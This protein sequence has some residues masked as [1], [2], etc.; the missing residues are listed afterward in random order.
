MANHT[1]SGN[2]PE[3]VNFSWLELASGFWEEFSRIIGDPGSSP[4]EIED[5][6]SEENSLKDKYR[7]YK[8]WKTG[9][10]NLTTFI[11]MITRQD[12]REAV[13]EAMVTFFEFLTQITG[14]SSEN[15]LEF[16]SQLLDS[17]SRIGEHT[18]AYNFDDI[19][20]HIFESFRKLYNTEFKKYL[21]IPKLGLPRFHIERISVLIDKYN[22]YYSYLNEL[23]YLFFVPLEKTN[24]IMQSKIDE[25]MT[26]KDFAAD[27]GRLYNEWIKMLEG[28]YMKLLQS[29][30]YTGT[31]KNT[32]NALADYRKSKNEVVCLF[33]KNLPIP[34]NREMDDIYKELYMM[35]KQIKELAHQL[36][37]INSRSADPAC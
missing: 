10:K 1:N 19:D 2:E 18:R 33:L 36:D 23:I 9:L 27:S 4:V 29:G 35:K 17:I 7:T 16:Q 3:R 5:D 8:T 24:R 34:T 37:Q 30:E 21:Y 14:D 13:S 6:D 12:N 25:M 31:L 11:E 22:I 15:I 20:Q 32:I 26:Q 28:H